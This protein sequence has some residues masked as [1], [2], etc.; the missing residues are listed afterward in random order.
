MPE[1]SG[2]SPR[3]HGILQFALQCGQNA[4]T[5]E[6]RVPCILIASTLDFTASYSVEELGQRVSS[7][8]ELFAI[9]PLPDQI[10]LYAILAPTHWQLETG[11]E[12][13]CL[14]I[15]TGEKQSDIHLK[16]ILPY[17][18]SGG[19]SYRITRDPIFIGESPSF[20]SEQSSFAT[21]HRFSFISER[22]LSSKLLRR[23]VPDFARLAVLMH[24]PALG[25]SHGEILSLYDNLGYDSKPIESVIREVVGYV[26]DKSGQD[27]WAAVQLSHVLQRASPPAQVFPL[28]FLGIDPDLEPFKWENLKRYEPVSNIWFQGTGQFPLKTPMSGFP[29]QNPA[30]LQAM[31]NGSSA[32]IPF[33]RLTQPGQD[34]YEWVGNLVGA[35]ATIEITQLISSWASHHAALILESQRAGIAVPDIGDAL[36]ERVIGNDSELVLFDSEFLRLAG[37]AMSTKFV[38]H[39]DRICTERGKLP[40]TERLGDVNWRM[41]GRIVKLFLDNSDQSKDFDGPRKYGANPRN[42][43]V[44]TERITEYLHES[45]ALIQNARGEIASGREPAT[46][47]RYHQVQFP[48]PPERRCLVP[49]D[50]QV[51]TLADFGIRIASVFGPD[52]L[53]DYYNSLEDFED[54]PY[55]KLLG[56]YGDTAKCGDLGAWEGPQISDD[57]LFIDVEM[58]EGPES[59]AE[60]FECLLALSKNSVQIS[61]VESIL[62]SEGE[63]GSSAVKFR[64]RAENMQFE[65]EFISGSDYID[66]AM[67]NR[68][69]D[70]LDSIGV[71]KRIVEVL[72]RGLGGLFLCLDSSRIS[73]F[74][75]TTGLPRANG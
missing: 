36:V 9:A 4:L 65:W 20:F 34:L 44:W 69:N 67:I 37:Q 27:A 62:V 23:Q 66:L 59:Y 11:E 46:L 30:A 55:M 31:A 35:L 72:Y 19:D 68:F 33:L 6:K 12:S 40:D 54:A 53:V 25:A 24:R 64:F 73:E 70:M 32:L 38:C 17:E 8:L 42:I 52:V 39:I 50:V 61:N 15:Y 58:Y 16:V 10:Q 21:D 14:A 28:I 48:K 60:L 5:I 2:I 56:R 1:D 57:V 43:F 71:E 13:T 49:L 3:L 51:Q 22:V 41:E 26:R 45:I 29:V 63:D 74:F 75:K 7:L 18:T 47:K